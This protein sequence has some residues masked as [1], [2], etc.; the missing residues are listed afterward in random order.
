[1]HWPRSKRT[2]ATRVPGLGGEPRELG[3]GLSVVRKNALLFVETAL[4]AAT[5]V[6]DKETTKAEDYA[7]FAGV[8]RLEKT[9]L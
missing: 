4:G 1:M 9:S 7:A 2:R 3:L 8:Q 5:K 6:R